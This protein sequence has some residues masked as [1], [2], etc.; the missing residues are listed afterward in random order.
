MTDEHGPVGP[1]DPEEQRFR[2]RMQLGSL[3]VTLALVSAEVMADVV[4]GLF[5]IGSFHASEAIVGTLVGGILV[6][7]GGEALRRLAGKK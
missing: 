6:L 3:V 5:S 1:A 2:Q 7:S 4:S